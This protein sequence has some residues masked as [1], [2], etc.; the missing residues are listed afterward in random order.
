LHNIP[1]YFFRFQLKYEAPL[2]ALGDD[3]ALDLI[4]LTCNKGHVSLYGRP[5]NYDVGIVIFVHLYGKMYND[6]GEWGQIFKCPKYYTAAE[7]R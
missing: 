3:T 6:F 5:K 7:F 4:K 2:G 1:G